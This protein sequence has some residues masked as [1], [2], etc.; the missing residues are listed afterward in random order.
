MN[1]IDT[2]GFW[3]KM[4]VAMRFSFASMKWPAFLA[5]AMAMVLSAEAQDG[6]Q[7]ILFSAPTGG[8]TSVLKAPASGESTL[9]DR[10]ANGFQARSSL[11]FNP[12][13]D[14]APPPVAV[15]TVTGQQSKRK[16]WVFMTP[17][18]ILGITTPDK[19]TQIS[20]RDTMSLTPS[21][22]FTGQDRSGGNT[23]NNQ[24]AT[25]PNFVS[26]KL[27]D[28]SPA[29]N[30]YLNAASGNDDHLFTR[31]YDNPGNTAGFGFSASA[32]TPTASPYAPQQTDWD[33]FKQLL[34]HQSSAD[35]TAASDNSIYTS[36]L[37]SNPNSD[38]SPANSVGASY[39]PL[40]SL[41]QPAGLTPPS[42]IGNRN[43]SQPSA[44]PAW[45]PKLPPW[46]TQGPQPFVIPQRKF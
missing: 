32:P 31:Q 44:P 16:D 42:G 11:N 22:N 15:P 1:F 37:P 14:S 19:T 36:K 38:Q 3:D 9:S 4:P 26:D 25:L 18:E 35:A 29:W 5:G 39:T 33:H 23:G 7:P 27:S 20:E 43:S 45:A 41:A 21:Q 40:P 28:S 2:R 34:Q 24:S 6:T 8:G 10:F 12:P 46:M 13:A 17:E 30:H